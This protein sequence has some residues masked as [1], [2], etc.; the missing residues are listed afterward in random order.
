MQTLLKRGAVRAT[1]SYGGARRSS[2][3]ASTGR[4]EGRASMR[5]VDYDA[6][7]R[8]GSW[9]KRRQGL[10]T[11]ASGLVLGYAGRD[12]EKAGHRRHG[13]ILPYNTE[14]DFIYDD[15]FSRTHEE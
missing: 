3:S 15:D 13:A 10:P 6:P 7:C 11:Q 2:D 4:R 5:A 14:H 12:K 1:A 8:E 9:Q